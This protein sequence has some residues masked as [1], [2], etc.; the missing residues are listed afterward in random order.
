MIFDTYVSINMVA[1]T[2]DI[3]GIPEVTAEAAN[4]GA[5]LEIS[6]V[7][8]LPGDAKITVTA[9]NG[10]NAAYFDYYAGT[11]K[12]KTV[13][14]LYWSAKTLEGNALVK[15]FTPPIKAVEMVREFDKE[16]NIIAIY[17]KV[18]N[19]YKKGVEG[20]ANIEQ[21]TYGADM[22][23]LEFEGEQIGFYENL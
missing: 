1:L 22:D 3:T 5:S 15:D 14:S 9:E 19:D 6:Q 7:E 11:N 18:Y 16:Q 12:L 23:T 4:P 21:A 17:L 10:N 8:S 2:S 20:V 13:R